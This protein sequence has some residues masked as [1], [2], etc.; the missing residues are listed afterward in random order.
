MDMSDKKKRR[1]KHTYM[2]MVCIHSIGNIDMCFLITNIYINNLN[3]ILR[4]TL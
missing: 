2:Y 3:F 1:R 4:L